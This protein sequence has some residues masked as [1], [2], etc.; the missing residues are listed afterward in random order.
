MVVDSYSNHHKV[1]P[2]GFS[3]ASHESVSVF[4]KIISIAYFTMIGHK[5]TGYK[6]SQLPQ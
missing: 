3:T 4:S 2:V 5:V 6:I 1:F